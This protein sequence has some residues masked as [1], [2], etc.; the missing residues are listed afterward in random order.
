MAGIDNII[1]GLNKKYKKDIVL[2]GGEVKERD[3]IPFSSPKANWLTR[4]G[5]VVGGMCELYGTEGSGKTTTAIDIM[6]NFQ[7]KFP[8]KWVVYLDAENIF[9]ED[10][11]TKLGVDMSK[12]IMIKPDEECAEVLLDIMLDAIR[13]GDVGLAIVDSIPFLMSKQEMEGD[14]GDKTYAGNSAV[15]TV[16]SRKVMP[17]LNRTGCTCIMINQVR[18]KMG[19]PYT[20]YNTPGK[21]CPSI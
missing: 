15:M 1:K 19:V 17:N 18:D 6:Y 13:T 14:L 3:F 16:F 12:V 11:A 10:W 9:D 5:I 21:L 20:A 4:G 7:I 8:N 2:K